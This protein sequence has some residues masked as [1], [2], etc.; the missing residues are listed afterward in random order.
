M[1]LHHCPEWDYMIIDES[2]EEIF[3]CCCFNDLEFVKLR[4]EMN[5]KIRKS[6]SEKAS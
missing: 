5:L 2:D 3:C 1:Y 4:E 6:T